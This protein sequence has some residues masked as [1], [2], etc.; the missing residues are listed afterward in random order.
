MIMVVTCKALKLFW[1][2]TVNNNMNGD[3]LR[4]IRRLVCFVSGLRA[5][6]L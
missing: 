3:L 1:G 6:D 4:T 5:I 2:E